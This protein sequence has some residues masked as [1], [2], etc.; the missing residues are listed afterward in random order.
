MGKSRSEKALINSSASLIN[1]IISLICGLILPRLILTTFGSDYNGI[2][3]SITQF[4]SCI[5]LMQAGIGSVTR[6]ALYKPLANKDYREISLIVAQTEKFMRRVALIFLGAILVFAA[7]YPIWIRNDFDWFF[8]FSLIL[9]I[10]ISTF[11]QYFFGIT[12]QMVLYADQRHSIPSLVNMGMTVLNTVVS[13]IL[14]KLGQGIHIVKLG[15]SFVYVL[16]PLFYYGYVKKKYHI[17]TSVHGDRDYLSQ[18][19]DAFGHEVANFVNN[20]TDI[21]VLS[22]F[23]SLGNVSVYTIYN[24]VI[25][26]ITKVFDMFVTGFGSAFGNMYALK[27][28]DLMKTNLRIYELLVY[29]LVSIIY[30][31]TFVMI[32]PFVMVYTKGVVDAQY[33]QPVFAGVLTLASA[34]NCLRTP[35]QSIVTAVGHFKQ[36]RNGAFIEAGINIVVSIACVIKYGLVGVAIGTLVSMIYRTF[37]FGIYLSKNILPRSIFEI[38]KHILVACFVLLSTLFC[39]RFYLVH[40]ENYWQWA[41][42]ALLTTVVAIVAT[43][44]SDFI[45]YYKDLKTLVRKLGGLK[46]SINIRLKG[47]K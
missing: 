15:S 23:S 2:T 33:H 40:I 39:S 34:F 32:T 17:D 47:K 12:Y 45:F 36:T 19:W 10:A 9:I 44:I 20:N 16:G 31:V 21:M 37:R 6:A 24:Y 14:I 41:L 26:N 8:T 27:E 46:Q 30:S 29:S 7:I 38:I 28:Y 43:L 11:A 22:V 5:S 25:F 42:Y 4:I 3:S 1:E 35:Y 13:V 18:R